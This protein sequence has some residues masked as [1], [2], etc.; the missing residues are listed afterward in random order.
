MVPCTPQADVRRNLFFWYL[1]LCK[2]D[3]GTSYAGNLKIFFILFFLC[4][5]P[6]TFLCIFDVLTPQEFWEPQDT[7][8]S[9]VHLTLFGNSDTSELWYSATSELQILA[10]Q[11]ILTL[12]EFWH[13]RNSDTSRILWPLTLYCTLMYLGYYVLTLV[14]LKDLYV[15]VWSCTKYYVLNLKNLTLQWWSCTS[16]PRL[17]LCTGL[18]IPNGSWSS[19]MIYF[20]K[21]LVGCRDALF[22][23]T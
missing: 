16:I 14:Y 18:Y 5:E 20:S 12:Q 4:V 3:V 15:Q 2:N 17:L 19:R 22:Y 7:V 11:E 13:F 21:P 1:V 8:L 10:L 6:G 23:E 9:Y